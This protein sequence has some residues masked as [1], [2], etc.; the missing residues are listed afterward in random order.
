MVAVQ[1][2]C[3]KKAAETVGFGSE[4]IDKDS[5]ASFLMSK[6]AR[7]SGGGVCRVH[8]G[9]RVVVCQSIGT[10]ALCS[11]EQTAFSLIKFPLLH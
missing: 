11:I 4:G 9:G 2:R 1:S 6:D 10:S 8:K 3:C 5:F 7:D